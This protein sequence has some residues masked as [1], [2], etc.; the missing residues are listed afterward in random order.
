MNNNCNI[1]E[2]TFLL[3]VDVMSFFLEDNGELVEY[4]STKQRLT[5]AKVAFEDSISLRYRRRRFKGL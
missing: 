2:L 1:L 5:L 3:L 4:F